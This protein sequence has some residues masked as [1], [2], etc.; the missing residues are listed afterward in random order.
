MKSLFVLAAL[1]VACGPA[2]AA[3]P[4]CDNT[5]VLE[6][7]EYLMLGGDKAWSPF[8][9]HDLHELQSVD[10]EKIVAHFRQVYQ[11]LA[12]NPLAAIIPTLEHLAVESTIATKTQIVDVSHSQTIGYDEPSKTYR[13]Q[14]SVTYNQASF[15]PSMR[16]AFVNGFIRNLGNNTAFS[17]V[18]VPHPKFMEVVDQTL[19]LM[20]QCFNPTITYTVNDYGY[21]VYDDASTADPTCINN[22]QQQGKMLLINMMA[23]LRK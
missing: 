13:C 23:T 7:V 9:V 2:M 19:E 16:I 18:L 8:G 14:A 1:V 6:T 12:A 5:A 17:L 21:V 11:A 22:A 10:N 15:G 20:R 4:K 3:P